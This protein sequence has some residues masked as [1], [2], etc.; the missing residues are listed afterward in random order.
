MHPTRRIS[1]LAAALLLIVTALGAVTAR[2]QEKR[3]LSA[4][5][6]LN[7]QIERAEEEIRKNTL[8]LNEIVSDKKS[9]ERQLKLIRSRITNRRNIVTSLGRQIDMISGEIG[10]RNRRIARL[11]EELEKLKG[12]YASMIRSS[13]INY[14]LNNPLALLFSARDFN[15]VSR[16]IYYMRRY[17]ALRER[18]AAEIDSLSRSLASEVVDLDRRRELLD[19]K[20]SLRTAEIT[21]LGKDEKQ[22]DTAVKSLRKSESR[23]AGQIR[24]RQQEIQRAQEQIKKLIAQE[25]RE[26]TSRELT[27]AQR[28][29]I[30]ALTGSFEQNAAKLPYPVS[31]GVIIDRFGRHPHPT[32][33][34]VQV[35]NTGVNI[36]AA[37][38]AEVRSV[39]DGVVVRIFFYQGLNNSVMVRHGSYITVY[40]N[41]A[42]VAVKKGDKVKLGQ[43]LGSLSSGSDDSDH[44]LHFEVWKETQ[45]LNPE[46]WLQH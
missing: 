2:A 46:T 26:N 33:R 29:E 41:L 11:K 38:G 32:Q 40:S 31:G 14:K 19:G 20:K 12:D 44:V 45:N 43:R 34:G 39:F 18:K 1:L 4:L 13:Y 3:E 17:N 35:N 10:T 25:S 9:N 37:R 23:V 5:E 24:T 21:T 7:A 27:T 15:D 16:R 36:A 6:K 28:R 30:T 42:D 22:Y 8:L